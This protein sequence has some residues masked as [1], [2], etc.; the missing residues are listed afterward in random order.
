MAFA[1]FDQIGGAFIL[2]GGVI[3]LKGGVYDQLGISCSIDL[4]S[5]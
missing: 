3:D 2:W 1:I 5:V 4:L